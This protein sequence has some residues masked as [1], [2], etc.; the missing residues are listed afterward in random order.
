[1]IIECSPL[2][3]SV[4][5]G[6]HKKV[7]DWGVKTHEPSC[8]DQLETMSS[9]GSWWCFHQYVDECLKGRINGEKNA[10]LDKWK[11][12]RQFKKT[13][14]A[15]VCSTWNKNPMANN[16]TN[17]LS[18]YVRA[19]KYLAFHCH[20][21]LCKN[22][23]VSAGRCPP[24]THNLSNLSLYPTFLSIITFSFLRPYLSLSF[25]P[26]HSSCSVLH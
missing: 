26:H 7:N 16:K 24:H 21:F 20:S 12:S 1:M 25:C 17:I 15:V 9:K 18:L 14:P 3:C 11:G 4:M 2:V 22:L 13:A 10:S 6:W 5:G 23:P 8:R 19:N